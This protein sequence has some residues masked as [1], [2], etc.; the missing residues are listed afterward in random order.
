MNILLSCSVSILAARQK[1]HVSPLVGRDNPGEGLF[2]AWFTLIF[3]HLCV[4]TF[5]C[6]PR[7]CNYSG[8]LII[9]V[10]HPLPPDSYLAK[11]FV[12]KLLCCNV[13]VFVECISVL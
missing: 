6:L 13:C 8:G 3:I 1:P 4:Y 10:F 9:L 5:G 12:S 2:Y 7:L 11:S